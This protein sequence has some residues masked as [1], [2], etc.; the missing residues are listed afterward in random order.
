MPNV[1]SAAGGFLVLLALVLSPAAP[2]AAPMT[3]LLDAAGGS[4]TITLSASTKRLHGA[5]WL[6]LANP[7]AGVAQGKATVSC[8]EKQRQGTLGTI[9]WFRFRIHSGAR[10]EIWRGAKKAPALCTVSVTLTGHGKLSGSL[11]GY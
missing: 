4:G 1:R 8:Q 11:R 3:L 2:A 5:V 10:Q 7:S 9:G 6:L